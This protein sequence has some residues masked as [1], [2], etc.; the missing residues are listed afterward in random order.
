M[1]GLRQSL[2]DVHNYGISV[3]KRDIYL[4]SYYI[5]DNE[6]N[7]PGVDYR[8]AT[9]FIKNYH[10][11]DQEP[12]EPVLVHLHSDG[13]CWQN[14]MAI[15]NTIQFGGSPVTMLAYSQAV[16]MS[17][18]LLQSAKKRVLMPDCYF[19]MHHGWSGGFVHHPFANKNEADYQI[20]I[21]KRMLDIFSERAVN[22]EFFKKK[23]SATKET[24]YKFFDHKLKK[25]VDWYMVADEALYYGLCD[26]ILG[27][28][29]FPDV[30]S[31][32]ESV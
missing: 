14:G 13:G 24:A 6:D 7:E 20:V 19:M 17:G 3:E 2:H 18:V 26:G 23:K 31:L 32:R 1:A 25:E 16:S 30:A 29:E 15:F 4:H 21:C 27:S 11:L 5:E 12:Y 28:K 8:Q 22:G 9:T 10:L